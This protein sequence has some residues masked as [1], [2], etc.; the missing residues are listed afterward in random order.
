MASKAREYEY[1]V[2]GGGT[3]GCV[4]ANRL[5]ECSDYRVLV[6]EAGSTDD[7]TRIA[8]PKASHDLHRSE[9]DWGMRTTPQRGLRGRRIEIPQGKVLG[10]C[11]C[12]CMVIESGA[13]VVSALE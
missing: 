3:A 12:C 2:V 9:Y 10:G 13:D 7:T 6:L 4:L 8:N 11:C 5:S 1:I